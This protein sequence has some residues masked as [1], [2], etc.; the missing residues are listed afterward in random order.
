MTLRELMLSVNESDFRDS[1][2]FHQ[3]K[4]VQPE[5]GSNI[6]IKVCK[7][8]DA[9][10]VTNVHVGS[11]GD[12]LASPI[13]VSEDLKLSGDELLKAI[14]DAMTH[15]GFTEAD[16]EMFWDDMTNLQKARIVR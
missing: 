3:L 12:I 10:S 9:I 1:N 13:D 6:R 4:D 7:R 14:L 8:G 11:P 16:S 15:K 2:L 5:Y